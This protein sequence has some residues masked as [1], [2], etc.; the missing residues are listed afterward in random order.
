[1]PPVNEE[2]SEPGLPSAPFNSY[3]VSRRAEPNK[4][5]PRSLVLVYVV[6]SVHYGNHRVTQLSASPSTARTI[7]ADERLHQFLLL[8]SRERHV[9]VII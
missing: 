8:V 3:G 7:H 5:A 1:M 4:W 2:A 9:V 6:S